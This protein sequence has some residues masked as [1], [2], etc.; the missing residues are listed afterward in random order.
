MKAAKIAPDSML[1]LLN[2]DAVPPVEGVTEVLLGAG[3]LLAPEA[4]P[5]EVPLLDPPPE[6]LPLEALL[7]G[8]PL[9]ELLLAELVPLAGLLLPVAVPVE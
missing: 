2:A 7:L 5:P 3:V 4:L 6:P 8:P 9:L 1:A